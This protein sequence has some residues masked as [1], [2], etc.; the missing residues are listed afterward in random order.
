MIIVSGVKIPGSELHDEKKCFSLSFVTFMKKLLVLIFVLAALM[1][2]VIAYLALMPGT[3]FESKKEFLFVRDGKPAKEQVMEQVAEEN[4][5]QHPS[6]FQLLA[7]NMGVWDKLKPGRFEI[8]NGESL[9]KIVRKLR[10]NQQSPVKLVINKIRLHEDFAALIEK[11][12]DKDSSRVMDYISNNDSLRQWGV[13]STSFL[14]LIIPDTYEYYWT[15]S[16]K[17]IMTKL[18]DAHKN[19]WSKAGREQKLAASGLTKEQVYII[20]SIV[21]E[22]TNKNDEKGNVASVYINR[23]RKGMPLGADPT[24]KFAVKDFTIKRVLHA[25]LE[26]SS[27]YNTYRNQGLPPGP[28]CTPSKASIDAVLDAPKTNYLFF[29]AKA[30]FSGYHVF[31]TNFRD[32]QNYARVYQK[33][34]DEMMKKKQAQ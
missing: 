23:L 25:H 4:L 2:A 5:L 20:A 34:L 14:T 30:D 33:A 31:T 7:A 19:F 10:N 24:V 22:E 16:M 21:E 28:I 29:V 32:H 13:D 12:F 18:S 11:E 6:A 27:P 17:R 3:A 9:L 26:T 8:E 1:A 15:A